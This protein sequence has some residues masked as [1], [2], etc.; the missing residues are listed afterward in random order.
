[1][2]RKHKATAEAAIAAHN[3]R[4]GK[5]ILKLSVDFSPRGFLTKRISKAQ[6]LHIALEPE[7]KTLGI[8]PLNLYGKVKGC[9]MELQE[10]VIPDERLADLR[11]LRSEAC[12]L[13]VTLEAN[14]DQEDLPGMETGVE[15]QDGVDGGLD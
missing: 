12:S 1:M 3:A 4:K 9:V 10:L 7:D 2:S 5:E 13:K 14:D 15:L 6:P 8:E 11:F